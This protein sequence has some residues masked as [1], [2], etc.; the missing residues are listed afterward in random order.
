MS[1]AG[2]RDLLLY[3]V[4]FDCLEFCKPLYFLLS[5][6]KKLKYYEKKEWKINKDQNETQNK[7][8][9]QHFCSEKKN[10]K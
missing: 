10:I 2:S 3:E 7:L 6:G 9:S 4:F 5:F 1:W 8:W